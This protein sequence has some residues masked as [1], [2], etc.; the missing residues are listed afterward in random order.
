MSPSLGTQLRR[1]IE[2][3]DGEVE[4]RYV[5]LG[6]AYRPRF[7]PVVRALEALGPASIR[8]ISQHSGL[9][10]SAASQT[11][12]QMEKD[13]LLRIR[14]GDDGRERIAEPTPKLL[15]MTAALHVQWEAT[16]RAAEALDREL[17]A[18]LLGI[19]GEAIAALQQRSFGERIAAEADEGMKRTAVPRKKR[20]ANEKTE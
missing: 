11:V 16:T 18:S 20:T 17:S 3:L 8:S 10:H 7:T 13:G 19:V 6:L 9:S 5:A 2:L 14:G 1:L 4:R 15:A 12:A